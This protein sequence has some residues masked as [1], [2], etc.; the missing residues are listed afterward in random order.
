MLNRLRKLLGLQKNQEETLPTD[1]QARASTLP[2][3]PRK[4]RSTAPKE[5]E[6][7]PMLMIAVGQKG[8]GKT[9]TSTGEMENYVAKLQRPVIIFDTNDEY[10]QYKPIR[11]KDIK[12]L[13]APEIR[14]VRPVVE[15]TERTNRKGK[16]IIKTRDMDLDEKVEALKTILKKCRNMMVV[17]EDFNSYATNTRA[18]GVISHIVNNRQRSQ[19]ILFHLQSMSKIDPTLWE[20]TAVVRLHR[21]ADDLERYIERVPQKELVRLAYLYIEEAY[22]AGHTREYVYVELWNIKIGGVA[23]PELFAKACENYLLMNPQARK[24]W[25][26]KLKTK[27]REAVNQAFLEYAKKQYL[28]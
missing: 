17:F 6:R 18:S 2:A 25:E 3:K 28:K 27:N 22:N 11:L 7:E 5:G 21:Q 19:D 8:V 16:T 24:T 1:T 23:Y 20:N 9:Y 13:E 10:K 12:K 4:V 14:R 15:L 26:V